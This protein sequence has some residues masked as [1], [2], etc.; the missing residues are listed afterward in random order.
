MVSTRR[1]DVSKNLRL[2]CLSLI[3]CMT[4]IPARLK[5]DLPVGPNLLPNGDF[6]E[7]VPA[8]DSPLGWVFMP[9]GNTARCGLED[10]AV[11]LSCE[12]REDVAYCSCPQKTDVLA[13]HYYLL[14]M[15]LKVQDVSE[16]SHRATLIYNW[17][18]ADGQA[19][20]LHAWEISGT[21]DWQ[22][23]REVLKAPLDAKSMG[24]VSLSVYQATGTAWFDDV[25]FQE[26]KLSPERFFADKDISLIA[27]IDPQISNRQDIAEELPPD[28]F[29]GLVPEAEM[30]KPP[31]SLWDVPLLRYQFFP[32]D[33]WRPG[34]T[35][36][37]DQS[38]PRLR[39]ALGQP[40]PEGQEYA[41][42]TDVKYN[43]IIQEHGGYSSRW[44]PR[45]MGNWADSYYLPSYLMTGDQ[46]FLRRGRDM[47]DYLLYSQWLPDGSNGFC[48]DHYPED[49]QR[50]TAEGWPKK[51]VGGYDYLFD[52]EWTDGYGYTWPLHSTD[53]HVASGQA[54]ALIMGYEITGDKKY[55]DSAR[56]FV[57]EHVPHYGFHTG[58]WR[59][60]RYYWTEYNPTGPG[61]P[62]A[63][64][65][66]NIQALVAVPVAMLGYYLNDR[67][68][69]EYARGLLWYM[70]REWHTDKRWYYD[71]WENPTNKRYAISHDESCL[72]GIERSLPYLLAA[73]VDCR[74]LL[75]GLEQPLH[76]YMTAHDSP[77]P[78]VRGN[79]VFGS[80][81]E[82]APGKRLRF[83]TYVQVTGPGAQEVKFADQ[84]PAGF[85]VREPLR[86]SVTQVG[87][88][89]REVKHV[90]LQ[91]LG[92]GLSLNLPMKVG[93]IYRLEYQAECPAGFSPTP[94]AT[95]TRERPTVNPSVP[96][97]QMKFVNELEEDL[98]QEFPAQNWETLKK[99][100]AG[101]YLTFNEVLRFP[102]AQ[103]RSMGAVAAH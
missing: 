102:K 76:F 80:W 73:G 64:A 40:V 13:N 29:W 71:G 57:R 30:T 8:G 22:T 1:L 10:G 16:T 87:G 42:A 72:Y 63:D 60:Q 12:S 52:W 3:L 78:Y 36:W 62:V 95:D 37:R 98:R 26:V 27:P 4:L 53:H 96:V 23:Y 67:R 33:F 56:L 92:D 17:A 34:T 68:L 97:S 99:V 18:T 100:N 25:A 54:A 20:Q 6:T 44:Y 70:C 61:N 21:T 38:I 31:D 91:Q 19:K 79:K 45:R 81:Q 94:T 55:L 39:G 66:D 83:V 88:G 65:T 51:W 47:L 48:R 84:L 86:L 15:R 35:R 85:R 2:I 90:T 69:L 7:A 77:S 89:F 41:I 93:D 11:R 82:A 74:A 49:F 32:V 9:Q 43:P 28:R 59:G 103:R 75:E 58:V 5:A 50:L 46:F 14:T 101:N 24:P